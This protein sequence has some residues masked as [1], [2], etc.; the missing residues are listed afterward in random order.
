VGEVEAMN[1]LDSARAARN[2]AGIDAGTEFAVWGHSQGG[3][4]SLFTGENAATYAPELDLVA[5]AA[6]GPAPDPIDLFKVNVETTIGKVLI[7]MAMQSWAEVYDDASLDQI[8]APSAR[9][10]VRDIARNCLYEKW[11]VLASVPSALALNVRFLSAPPW[12]TEPWRTIAS[13]NT[14]GQQRIGVPV[15]VVQSEADTIITAD[16]TR[17]YVDARCADGEEV[18][19]LSLTGVGHVETGIDAAPDV[20]DWI[21]A[22]FAGEPVTAS[23]EG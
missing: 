16:V 20:A 10:V 8:V 17:R 3:H 4:A 6:G 21:D 7:A 12:E 5:V 22:R 19:V 11:Q 23:C 9:P 13:E 15:L 1:A 18:E 2:L 14:P